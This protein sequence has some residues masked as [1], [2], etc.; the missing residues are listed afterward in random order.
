M[1]TLPIAAALLVLAAGAVPP[2]PAPGPA[3]AGPPPAV[4]PPG[5]A[6]EL[7]LAAALDE[8]DR[9]N[10][11]L[12]QARARA[13]EAGAIARQTWSALLPTVTAV[14][15]YYKNR[16]DFVIVAPGV[17]PGD[18][19]RRVA[20]QPLEAFSAT[21]TARIPLLA[22]SSWW[23]VAAAREVARG[24]GATLEATRR[25]LRAAFAQAAH[26]SRAAEE[27][28]AASEAAVKSAA[29]L[30]RSAARRVAAGT[31]PPLD[32][33]RA[34]TDRTARESDLAQARANVERSRLALGVLLGRDR[35]VR[36]VAPDVA[37][38]ADA[39]SPEALGRAALAARPEVAA[40]RA[41]VA[42]AEAQVRAAWARLAP[43]LS[44]S[45]SYFAQDVA[46]PTG[47]KDGWKATVD[48]TWPI[49]DG[50]FRYGKRRQ[51]RAQLSAAR[52]GEE[53]ERLAVLQEVTD[54][55]RDVAVAIERLR[56]A[57]S[58][59]RL[60]ADAAASARRSFEAGVASSLDVIDANDRL[61]FAD[62]RLAE[63]RA[64]LAQASVSLDR[65]AGR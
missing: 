47:E 50:G 10:P 27:L 56:L 45:A 31:S 60:A 64:Q 35:P 25:N 16:D 13:D 15:Q 11:T 44:A 55:S 37:A 12:A 51:A 39:A 8:L 14:G 46:F 22:P 9:A 41:Q 1:V 4:A 32:R 34:E 24:A 54:A 2:P 18:L 53:G 40:Q 21:G 65:A 62:V 38:P 6:D 36:V 43:Q 59:R 17:D 23:D 52:A 5:P 29:E 33:L 42:A 28:V 61:Y 3:D 7:P 63:A 30:E 19:P 20:I 58:Q 26:A 57:Q 49:Y 48:L